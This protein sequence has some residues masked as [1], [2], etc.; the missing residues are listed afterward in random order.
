MKKD[1]LNNK[2]NDDDKEEI[3]DKEEKNKGKTKII[4]K[5]ILL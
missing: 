5:F 4:K 3:H 2:L 1:I